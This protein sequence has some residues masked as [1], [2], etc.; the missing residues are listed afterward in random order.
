MDAIDAER[1][2][3][4][5]VASTARCDAPVGAAKD[6]C[7]QRSTSVSASVRDSE[8]SLPS[9]NSTESVSNDLNQ[10]GIGAS[11]EL[12]MELAEVENF[13]RLDGMDARSAVRT[14]S[15]AAGASDSD[16]LTGSDSP[17]DA[18]S[19]NLSDL[20]NVLLTQNNDRPD[21]EL[22][23]TA[24]ERRFGHTVRVIGFVVILL[25]V[26]YL[27]TTFCRFKMKKYIINKAMLIPSFVLFLM[28]STHVL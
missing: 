28:L 4:S 3:R 25:G 19:T 20:V 24:S 9:G 12:S 21:K 6:S 5:D 8:G 26:V 15:S 10:D 1:R 17:S 11:K 27:R 7:L 14:N 23:P 22:H 18:D 13:K 16:T 2:F